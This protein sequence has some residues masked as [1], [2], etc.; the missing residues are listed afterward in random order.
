MALGTGLRSESLPGQG[1]RVQDLA[2]PVLGSNRFSGRTDGT[3]RL[4]LMPGNY[5][6]SVLH[7][8]KSSRPTQGSPGCLADHPATESHPDVSV[9]RN[10][11]I[12]SETLKRA[13][14]EDRV[15]H[16][17]VPASVTPAPG[18]PELDSVPQWRHQTFAQLALDCLLLG[19]SA[20]PLQDPA[21]LGVAALLPSTRR[22]Q[23]TLS[24]FSHSFGR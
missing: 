21:R 17:F 5:S 16:K 2:H 6:I 20:L 18:A 8:A 23:S 12:A 7:R 1:S 4:F 9:A 14:I 3:H 15:L 13:R 24:Q 11:T 10:K 22:T 19:S